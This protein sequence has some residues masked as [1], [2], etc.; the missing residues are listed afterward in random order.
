MARRPFPKV[1]QGFLWR[2][3][4]KETSCTPFCDLDAYHI[5]TRKHNRRYH[6][7][8]VASTTLQQLLQVHPPPRQQN[9]PMPPSVKHSLAWAGYKFT[10]TVLEWVSPSLSQADPGDLLKDGM[11]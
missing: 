8:P 7:A 3:V 2:L 10:S 1:L 11:D 9:N 5:P 4:T 6:K